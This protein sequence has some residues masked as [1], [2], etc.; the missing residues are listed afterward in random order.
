MKTSPVSWRVKLAL[1]VF[2][3]VQGRGRRGHG[4]E[5]HWPIAKVIPETLPHAGPSTPRR[6]SPHC[7]RQQ[8]SWDSRD[9]PG[10]LSLKWL[11]ANWGIWGHWTPLTSLCRA[12]SLNAL[13]NLFTH[14]LFHPV[15]LGL[16]ASSPEWGS[17]YHPLSPPLST[18]L[19]F[20]WNSLS[21]ENT[22][23][24]ILHCPWSTCPLWP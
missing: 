1:H 24:C 17:S 5:Q 2:S 13:P 11:E 22:L 12:L 23:S 16:W 10:G 14:S 6:P 4:Y 9:P 15:T 20:L 21:T 3:L 8:V 18:L 19:C 7:H